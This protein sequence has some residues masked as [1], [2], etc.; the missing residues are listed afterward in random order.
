MKGV[1]VEHTLDL[2]CAELRQ[3]KAP[4]TPLFARLSVAS[5]AA[6]LLDG[7][8]GCSR[9]GPV[10]VIDETVFLKQGHPLCGVGR[11]YTGS[12]GRITNCQIGV[13][14]AYASDKAVPSLIVSFVCPTTG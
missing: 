10:L 3:V 5:S 7:G 14:A 8:L 9:R 4:F 11:Q 13:F 1:A 6:V 2:W 12:A